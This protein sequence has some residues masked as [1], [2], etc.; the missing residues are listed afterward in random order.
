MRGYDPKGR[1]ILHV[2][3]FSVDSPQVA[4]AGDKAE[5]GRRGLTSPKR[6]KVRVQ[7]CRRSWRLRGKI[8][9]RKEPRRRTQNLVANFSLVV[10]GKEL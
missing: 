4:L 5:S 3:V 10:H 2:G 6:Q 7:G 9:E 8:Q 1:A